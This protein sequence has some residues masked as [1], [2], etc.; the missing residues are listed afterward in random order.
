MALSSAFL[1]RLAE[2]FPPGSLYTDPADCWAYGYDNSRRQALPEAV[3]FPTTHAQT[4]ELTRLCNEHRVSLTARGR[5]TGTTGA[6]VPLRGGVVAS[7]ERMNRVVEFSPG[8]RYI[9]VEPGLTNQALQDFLKPHGFFWPP[10]PTSASFCSIGGN[11]AYNSAGPRAVKY[12]TPRENT[13]ALRAVTGQGTEIRTGVFT[14]KGV[15]GYDLTRLLLG[16]E[17]TLALITEAVLKL[18]PLPEAKRTMRAVYADLDHATE[19]ITR[20]MA[21]PAVPCALEFIDGNAIELIRRYSRAELPERAG[22]LLMIEVDGFAEGLAVQTESV[23]RAAGNEGLLEFRVAETADEIEALWQTRK[24][25]SPALRKVAPKKINEDVVVPVT[26][27]PKLIAG[28]NELS[29]RFDLPIVNFGHAGN[30]NI[31]V[32][33]LF[34]PDKPGETEKAHQCLDEMF[35]LVLRLHGTLSGEHGVGLEK[36]DF[37]DREIDSGALDL[38]RA[39]KHQFDPNNILNPDKTLPLHHR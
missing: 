3:V 1:R 28:L 4:V 23:R 35:S 18:T 29:R 17:G 32:N 7:F 25:L 10:D 39:I 8:N 12:G 13:L 21:Q 11:L 36:R 37:V 6:T 33:L 26:E 24:A 34:D 9:V 15:V 38:M 31:H 5:G 2:I 14:T 22:A 30:G 19:A 16:S 27:L 20:I